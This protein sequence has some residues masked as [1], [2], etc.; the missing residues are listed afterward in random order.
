MF[1]AGSTVS[2]DALA[3]WRN[4]AVARPGSCFH[5]WE[6]RL[7]SAAANGPISSGGVVALKICDTGGALARAR[8][9]FP[10]PRVASDPLIVNGVVFTLVQVPR[11]RA[12]RSGRA[13]RLRWGHG[14]TAV[15]E[16]QGNVDAGAAR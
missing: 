9:G 7:S 14:Q 16:P 13:S 15:D 11:R 1:S 6:A 10:R 2:A 5:Q 3:A 12:G 8:L 4:R